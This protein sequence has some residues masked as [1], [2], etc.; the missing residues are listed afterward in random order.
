MIGFITTQKT[1]DAFLADIA[2]GQLGRQYWTTGSFLIFTGKDAGQYF[3]PASDELLATPLRN[4]L[5]PMD[6]P[7]FHLSL[8]T[9]GG[10]E[11]RLDLDPAAI[12]DPDAEP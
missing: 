8:D 10:L 9:L 7:E 1:A 6:F 4:G 2:H 11:A 5:T 12:I 3:I